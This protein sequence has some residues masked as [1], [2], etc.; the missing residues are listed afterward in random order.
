MTVAKETTTTERRRKSVYTDKLGDRVCQAIATS[1]VG[2]KRMVAD[3]KTLPSESTIYLWVQLN[4]RF[5]EAYRAAR[6]QQAEVRRDACG[7]V[8][9]ECKIEV[10]ALVAK[11]NAVASMNAKILISLA[12]FEV[13][14][15][16]R[17]AA[18]LAP[19][20]KESSKD[21]SGGWRGGDRPFIDPANLANVIIV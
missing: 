4:T 19:I 12:K 17:L 10:K 14:V 13:D 1:I 11:G 18:W 20:E 15:H 21:D 16:Q 9:A 7:D 8:M 2:I 3:D 6:R 5:A